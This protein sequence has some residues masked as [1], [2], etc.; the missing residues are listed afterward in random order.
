M[1]NKKLVVLL[2]SIFGASAVAGIAAGCNNE[3]NPNTPTP[4]P[5]E[6]TQYTVS[7]D[8]NGGT[9]VPSQTVK[10]G[11]KITEP[12]APTKG[13]Y[14]FDGWYKDDDCTQKWDFDSDTVS[15]N[16]ELHAAW[17]IKDATADTYFDFVALKDGSY[18]IKL[19]LG[20]TLPEEVIFPSRHEDKNVTEIAVTGFQS[21]TAIKSIF[22]PSTIKVIGQQ[23]FRNAQNL[24][25]VE[26]AEGVETI[27]SNAF[28]G[29]KWVAGLKSGANYLGSCLFKYVGDD[30][31]VTVS[32]DTLGIAANAFENL[33]KLQTVSLPQTLKAVGNSAFAGCTA[34]KA[35]D[36]PNSVTAV[37]DKAFSG[38]TALADVK[39]GSGVL[40]IGSNAFNG[41]GIKTLEYNA[42]GEVDQLAFD[43]VSGEVSLTFGD[44]V[45]TIPTN[46]TK[47]LTGLKK[48]VLGSGISEIPAG[49]FDGLSSLTDYTSKGVITSIGA[50]AF[51][52]VG[53]KEFTIAGSVKTLGAGAFQS[54][55][56][57][58]VVYNAVEVGDTS[59]AGLVFA[60]CASLAEVEIG[61]GVK[62]VPANLFYG[63]SALKKVTFDADVQTIGMAAFRGTGLTGA[64][65]LPANL[66]E[67]GAEAF[68]GTPITSVTIP[69]KVTVIGSDAFAD[70]ADLATVNYNAVNATYSGTEAIF[71]NASKVE[72]G[73]GVKAVPAYFVKG[74]K[75]ITSITIPAGV[76]SVGAYAFNDCS[77]LQTISGI[78]A[79]S[80][81]GDHAIEDTPY[82]TNWLES[83]EGLIVS[84]TTLTSYKGEMP[85][86]YTLK[87]PEN[88]TAIGADA[89]ANQTNLVAIEFNEKLTSIGDNAF[90][91]SSLKG[92][93]A[94]PATLETIGKDA[95]RGLT[96]I[97]SVDFS[98]LTA[99][100][101]I[102]E[103]AFAG[104]SGATM[105]VVLPETMEEEGLK[106]HAFDGCSKLT[107]LTVKSAEG[108]GLKVIPTGSFLSTGLTR[109]D[110]GVSVEE[111]ADDWVYTVANSTGLSKVTTFLA[112]GLKKVG[113][114]GLACLP[115]TYDTSNIEVFGERAM[116]KYGGTSII[117]GENC[118]SI[119]AA[120]TYP[121]TAVTEQSTEKGLQ[122]LTTLEIKS[123]K[124]KEIP[125]FA[126]ARAIKLSKITFAE[127]VELAAGNHAF[128]ECNAVKSLDLSV[129]TSIGDYAFSYCY[130]DNVRNPQFNQKLNKIGNY[131]FEHTN[132]AGKIEIGQSFGE[133]FNAPSAFSYCQKITDI[134]FGGNIKIITRSGFSNLGP[135]N[136]IR[137]EEG[138]T[139][140]DGI[141]GLISDVYIP[142]TVKQLKANSAMAKKV[143]LAYTADSLDGVTI[144]KGAFGSTASIYGV[145]IPEG[146]KEAYNTK[147]AKDAFN[148]TWMFVYDN[149][150]DAK[151]LVV[152]ESGKLVMYL[153][154]SGSI[155][156]NEKVQSI[157]SAVLRSVSN[158]T[159]V[160]GNPYL[161]AVDSVVYNKKGDTLVFIPGAKKYTS[162]TIGADVTTIAEGA[163]AEVAYESSR[164]QGT[165]LNI[166]NV[167]AQTPPALNDTL[168]ETIT[169]INVPEGKLAAYTAAE[170]WKE[171]SLKLTD[172]SDTRAWIVDEN[173]TLLSYRV[174]NDKEVAETHHVIIPT[175]VK[176]IEK[177]AFAGITGS[178]IIVNKITVSE[179]VEK[180]SISANDA[181]A[182]INVTELVFGSKK[183]KDGS[184]YGG[185]FSYT[186]LKRLEKITVADGVERLPLGIFAYSNAKTVVISDTV[187]EIDEFAC[188]RM[189][190]LTTVELGNGVQKIGRYAFGNQS[191]GKNKIASIT[192]PASLQEIGECAFYTSAITKL[193]WN[194]KSATYTGA[195]SSTSKYPFYNCKISD[196]TIGD[197][198]ETIPSYVM[199]NFSSLKTL[200][201]PANV[202][203]ISANAFSDLRSCNITLNDGLVTIGDNAFYSAYYTNNFNKL[204]STLQTI[205][206]QAFYNIKIDSAT[207]AIPDSVQTIGE[208]AFNTLTTSAEGGKIALTMGKGLTS[209]GVQAFGNTTSVNSITW[210]CT[211]LED[212]GNSAFVKLTLTGAYNVP[213]T[214]KTIGTSA[215]AACTFDSGWEFYDGLESV[216][217][218]AF[219]AST[220]S[221][222]ITKFP[223][224]LKSLGA[225]AFAGSDFTG[226]WGTIDPTAELIKNSSNAFSGNENLTGKVN[227]PADVT[228][229]GGLFAGTGVTEIGLGNVTKLKDN[230]L[231]DCT[232]LTNL[233]LPAGL[234]EIG[235][236]ALSGLSGITKID[237]PT[238]QK[239]IPA[240]VFANCVNLE[241]ITIPAD[242][243]SI[244]ANAFQ[245]CVKLAKIE[246]P[247]SLTSIGSYAF[248]GC[249]LLANVTL[250]EKLT[251]IG[252]YAFQNCKGFTSFTFT[253]KITT[254][255]K[256]VL[257]G[258]ENIT[259]LT[260][261]STSSAADPKI[262][263]CNYAF[264]GLSKLTELRLDIWDIEADSSS[265]TT[266][267]G[268]HVFDGCTFKKVYYNVYDPH[269]ATAAP[270][271]LPDCVE[272]IIVSE[273]ANWAPLFVNPQTSKLKKLV[274]NSTS[275]AL[276]GSGGRVGKFDLP[277]DT[278]VYVPDSMFD[279]YME[280]W[281]KW[282]GQIK[283][284]S[285]LPKE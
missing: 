97:T 229:L 184:A 250:P 163:F 167:E 14:T 154:T 51:R 85:E 106:E 59:I 36:L 175:E 48:V 136:S 218:N 122:N 11:G 110:L 27:G 252:E 186:N 280:G 72:I 101:S 124:L 90:K 13:G 266:S 93:V 102:G 232:K 43:G 7:F 116:I 182:L 260:L 132:I 155:E 203:T 165:V 26:G 86:N 67:I 279:K 31:S 237:W 81:M 126:F 183:Y 28:F 84:G 158:I 83:Q 39:I 194:A 49:A 273:R 278:L 24:Q 255:S 53:L 145:V 195:T 269:W 18:S 149:E 22:I 12:A 268:N 259:E 129:F 261:P 247:E 267:T 284:L 282:A 265:V 199:S 271:L 140:I 161:K 212:I 227:L 66:T 211:A 56:L 42:N 108:K 55:A 234:T 41:A 241:S 210:N 117:I 242:V 121:G 89:F 80:D 240:G 150:L 157:G 10:K 249:T 134:V 221:G 123:T 206:K 143:H 216:G 17:K 248:D 191:G 98:K 204:P 283:K 8:T 254:I 274:I 187:K 38:C 135:I 112:P 235:S 71:L 207:Y 105:K 156:L 82:Y 6:E 270:E 119:G 32:E 169:T 256:G 96:G 201:I 176:V 193:V 264:S 281:A 243:T 94:L 68:Y 236:Y 159:V 173:G 147:W 75:N 45:T 1:K 40:T 209:I 15:A 131:A 205:G 30:V 4:P 146:A 99:L 214:V 275:E 137:Y 73:S 103:Y 35:I 63:V 200:V 185:S 276:A 44:G 133:E 115:V 21:N 177:D 180:W 33:K 64:L 164:F 95:F 104:C 77:K 88:V 244:G 152:D 144:D 226:D 118:T 74:N 170:G 2:V 3:Q 230:A 60:G 263:I 29:T 70:C 253:N 166:L 34:L 79:V 190:N 120:F 233:Q 202:K 196:L 188:T 246:L 141:E 220:F 223:T 238:A 181:T 19:K 114:Y 257:M 50:Q 189:D 219:K 172:P 208:K 178:N 62:N 179:N 168:P 47:K 65:E 100:K 109:V 272:E 16:T 87:V 138:I 174:K 139:E 222:T 251:T 151:G 113:R 239:T 162:F 57:T 92:D 277:K 76:T 58:K 192:I 20:Q 215:F 111:L 5:A 213:K 245:G 225:E 262:K 54:S 228:E 52:G 23:A 285:E 61:A 107:E 160:D 148:G 197:T 128:H 46:L 130:M 25:S 142:T 78:D 198:V 258:C 231:R 37:N 9:D 69:Q 171:L 217:A 91:G 125:D 224:S 153:S 127:G